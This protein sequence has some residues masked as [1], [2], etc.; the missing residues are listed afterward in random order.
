MFRILTYSAKF[1]EIGVCP[2][3]IRAGVSIQTAGSCDSSGDSAFPRVVKNS[4]KQDHEKHER[5]ET[6]KRE[7]Y[8]GCILPTFCVFRVPYMHM[9]F[10]RFIRQNVQSWLRAFTVHCSL[11]TV[12][13][14][15][16]TVHCSLFTVH[17]SLFT[18]HCSLFTVHCSLFF[19][20]SFALRKL[21][22]S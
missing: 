5:S 3:P 21:L 10:R 16:F 1:V 17:C 4:L 7:H 15:L 8:L 9:R 19:H 6:H 12:H 22:V 18:V 2:P 14:S 11:F 20:L 13:C